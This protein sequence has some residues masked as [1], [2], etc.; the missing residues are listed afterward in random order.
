VYN[1]DIHTEIHTYKL[2]IMKVSI[3][4]M[5][6]ASSIFHIVECGNST[7]QYKDTPFLRYN[8]LRGGDEKHIDQYKDIFI[9]QDK[10]II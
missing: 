7:D 6:I 10:N 4:F 3:I 9:K 5:L 2:L 1:K 8:S